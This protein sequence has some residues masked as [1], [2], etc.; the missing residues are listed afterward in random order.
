MDQNK[1]NNKHVKILSIAAM[2]M[3]SWFMAIVLK[4]GMQ[5]AFIYKKIEEASIDH[6]VR[7][8]E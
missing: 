1:G 8:G 3:L 4:D 6:K 2:E 5:N 7:W